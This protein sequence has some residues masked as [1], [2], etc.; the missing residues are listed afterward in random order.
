MVSCAWLFGVVGVGRPPPGR[1]V[2][3][4]GDFWRGWGAA[5]LGGVGGGGGRRLCCHGF[6]TMPD[7]AISPS[8]Q[9]DRPP[10]CLKTGSL[11]ADPCLI[12]VRTLHQV[13]L[14]IVSPG[15]PSRGSIKGV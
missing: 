7:S 6:R 1:A 5:P 8:G 15:E 13:I 10:K 2:R 4:R 14:Y 9:P 11:M 12:L 3:R